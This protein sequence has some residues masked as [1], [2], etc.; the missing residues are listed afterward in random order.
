MKYSQQP[1]L[2]CIP[3]FS[4]GRD[5]K[6]IDQ[7]CSS[8][9][10]VQN[11]KLLH[12]DMGYDANRTVI[13][14]AG[15]PEAVCEAAFRAVKTASELIDMRLHQG[16]HP[17]IGATDVLP[18]VPVSGISM[19][20]TVVL[21]HNLAKR[22][23]DELNIP[24]YCYEKAAFTEER[25]KLENCRKGQY[26][27]LKDKLTD[28]KWKPDFGPTK[29]N[30]K[31]GATIIG[32]RKFLIAYNVNLLTQS[33]D[34]AEKIASE[35]RESGSVVIDNRG[36]KVKIP[37]TLK[38]VKAIGWYIDEYEMAQV[39]MNL[40]DIDETPIHVAFEEVKKVALKYNVKVN[41][42]EIIGLVPLKAMLDAGLYYNNSDFKNPDILIDKT[43]SNLG[44]NTIKPFVSTDR[45][46]EMAYYKKD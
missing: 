38:A 23:G 37:G 11:V 30:E 20:E 28:L 22:V 16:V 12:V 14:F 46:I 19:D 32:A 45:I 17:R 5:K 40:T 29:F 21:A 4:E 6:I 34:I 26:E 3:N 8:I 2:E 24:V 10:S 13:T 31:A 18:L 27:G 43:V 35:I 7:I 1:I 41:G 39:S 44:L 15:Q 9:T 25:V 36:E 42:S 33:V